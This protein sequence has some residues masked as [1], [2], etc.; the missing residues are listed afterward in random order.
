MQYELTAN[1][2]VKRIEALV[3]AHPEILTMESA[4]DL[5]KVKELKCDDLQP[6]LFQAGWALGQVQRAHNGSGDSRG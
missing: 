5:F 6:S 3:P 4:W 1:E 2:L